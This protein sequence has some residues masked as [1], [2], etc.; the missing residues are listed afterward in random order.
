MDTHQVD[1]YTEDFLGTWALAFMAGFLASKGFLDLSDDAES[2]PGW[3]AAEQEGLV[4]MTK[5]PF[6][7]WSNA[8]AYM[9]LRPTMG[10][11]TPAPTLPPKPSL[12]E[13]VGLPSA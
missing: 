11:S 8:Q 10:Y 7:G 13:W 1:K 9:K 4:L 6:W 12:R 2:L 5:A 3:Q